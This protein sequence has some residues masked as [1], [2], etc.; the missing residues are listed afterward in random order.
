MDRL[1]FDRDDLLHERC[2]G[3][4]YDDDKASY[5]DQMPAT[6]IVLAKTRPKYPWEFEF[7]PLLTE[8]GT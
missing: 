4:T 8:A 2:D 7:R 3:C 6:D 5:A 1:H